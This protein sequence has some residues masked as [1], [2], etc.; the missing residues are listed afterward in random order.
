[1]TLGALIF[2]LELIL[3]LM[4]IPLMWYAAFFNWKLK[5]YVRKNYPERYHD[6]FG[7]LFPINIDQI[8]YFLRVWHF[9]WSDDEEDDEVIRK[10]KRRIRK[11][12]KFA[13]IPAII[14]ILTLLITIILYYY[15]PFL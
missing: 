11:A 12:S 13:L 3:A 2:G 7:G 6:I 1:M 8:G 5:L 9:L 4:I 10:Y 15:S 14:F